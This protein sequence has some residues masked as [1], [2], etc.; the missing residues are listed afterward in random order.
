MLAYH[1]AAPD[2]D[3]GA[4]VRGGRELAAGR[5]RDDL[6]YI[7]LLLIIMITMIIIKI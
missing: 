5:E 4:G 7:I 2:G 1:H 3:G 6:I